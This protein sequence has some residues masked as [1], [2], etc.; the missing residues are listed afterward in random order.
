MIKIADI[1]IFVV[2]LPHRTDRL[3]D[4]KTKLD[5]LGLTFTRWEATDGRTLE[6]PE[7]SRKYGERN[8]QGILGCLTSHVSLI[9]HAKEKQYKYI[10]VLE[11]DIVLAEDFV[12]RVNSVDRGFDMLYLGGHFEFPDKDIT[13]TD[14]PYVYKANQISGT[15]AYIIADNLYDYIIENATYTYGID[16]FYALKVHPVFNCLALIPWPVDHMAGYSDVAFNDV[17]YHLAHKYFKN[18]LD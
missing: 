14:N 7:D 13:P 6:V 4:M 1:P 17:D 18:K 5:N 3:N 12:E 16:E 10:V 8:A 9:K 2:N 15:Y 11:D